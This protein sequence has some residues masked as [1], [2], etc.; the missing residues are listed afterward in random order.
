MLSCLN[1]ILCC[2]NLILCCQNQILCCLNQMLCCLNQIHFPSTHMLMKKLCSFFLFWR[3]LVKI[4]AQ[5]SGTLTNQH[6]LW[7]S[8]DAKPQAHLFRNL[9]VLVV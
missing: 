6:S 3:Y 1:Q 5:L 8:P 4:W 9:Y 2:L 7:L